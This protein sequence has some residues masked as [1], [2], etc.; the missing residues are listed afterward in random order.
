MANAALDG[1]LD[2]YIL[3]LGDAEGDP[4]KQAYIDQSS[5]P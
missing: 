5:G 3:G 2:G 1:Y 4:D